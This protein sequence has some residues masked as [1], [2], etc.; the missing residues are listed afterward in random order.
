MINKIKAL[1]KVIIITTTAI[2]SYLLGKKLEQ[3]KQAQKDLKRMTSDKQAIQEQA[4]K[5][6]EVQDEA[7]RKK[8]AVTSDNVVAKLNELSNPNG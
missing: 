4:Q 6:K 7:N 5:A 3:G 1:A 8:A 2:L